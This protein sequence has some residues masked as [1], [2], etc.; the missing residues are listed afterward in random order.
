[1]SKT[2]RDIREQQE[3]AELMEKLTAADPTGKWISD[4]VKS[5]NP[6]FAGKSKKERIRMALGASYAAQRNEDVD[7]GEAGPFS[8]GVKSPRRGSVADLAAKKRKEQES[9]TKPIEPKDQMVGVAKKLSVAEGL[10]QKLRKLVPG[11]AKKQINQKMDA[12][13]FGKTDADKDANYYRY[14]KVLDKTNE[15]VQIDENINDHIAQT[16]A[17]KDIN[18]KVVGTKVHVHADNAAKARAIISKMGTA[19]TVHATLKEATDSDDLMSVHDT[20]KKI[21]VKH[22]K[23]SMHKDAT[24]KQRIYAKTMHKRALEAMKMKDHTAALNHYRGMSEEFEQIDEA[25]TQGNRNPQ[26]GIKVGHK[27]R[28]YD[29]PGMHDDHY[30]EGHVIGEGPHSYQIKVNRVVR[31]GKEMPVPAHMAH[32]EAP[33]GRGMFS[34]AYAVHKMLDKQNSVA[35]APAAATGAARTFSAMRQQVKE[36]QPAPVHMDYYKG[37][38]LNFARGNRGGKSS[39]SKGGPASDAAGNGGAGGNGGG[40]GE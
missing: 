23:D 24:N 33:K 15:E 2:L 7:L 40:N 35:A 1:M 34:Q 11:Y 6:K 17:D 29:F 27:V 37:I 30:I 18:A 3:I 36:S 20:Y 39:S 22:M 8:Y 16:L 25:W 28:S 26:K 9:K 5:D 4:F 32:V 19:H 38:K 13:K 31:G 10:Q 12:G 14:K 21:A